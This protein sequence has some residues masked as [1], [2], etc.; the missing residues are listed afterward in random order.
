LLFII[1]LISILVLEGDLLHDDKLKEKSAAK[2]V[3]REQSIASSPDVLVLGEALARHGRERNPK[4]HPRLMHGLQI[5]DQAH[6]TGHVLDR[7]SAQKRPL[8]VLPESY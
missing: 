2:S 7:K 1:F 6:G 8:P 4:P 5:Y 3:R